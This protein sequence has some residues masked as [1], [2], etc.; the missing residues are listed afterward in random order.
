MRL[1][2]FYNLTDEQMEYIARCILD[3]PDWN[4]P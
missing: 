2:L 3:Y 4:N 1:P